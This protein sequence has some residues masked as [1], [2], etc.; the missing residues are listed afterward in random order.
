[1]PTSE[2]TNLTQLVGKAI[3]RQR[4][5]TGLSQEQVAE[6]LGIGSEAVSRIERGVVMPNIERLMQFAEIF[7]C[8]AA[9]LLTQASTRSDDQAVRI[10]QMLNQLSADDRQLVLELVERLTQ[11][12][13]KG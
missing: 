2:Q 9:D 13:G 10:S 12:L 7:G 8:E 6:R 1:M 5:R 11:R 3:A 4:T